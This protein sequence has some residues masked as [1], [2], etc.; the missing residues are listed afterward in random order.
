ESNFGRQVLPEGS[1]RCGPF[2]Y[3]A[4]EQVRAGFSR[5][6]ALAPR[7]PRI[8]H[9]HLPQQ[10]APL[11]PAQPPAQAPALGPAG[12]GEAD[13][14]APTRA[15]QGQSGADA[16]DVL[17][18]RSGIPRLAL[19]AR[20]AVDDPAT[21]PDRVAP[22]AGAVGARAHGHG[23]PVLHRGDPGGGQG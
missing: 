17:E 11:E 8:V 16:F 15:S 9:H 6:V 2:A 13:P 3:G 22:T 1:Q 5:A 23:G 12:W 7:P 19:V 10:P 4:S 21:F 18:Y 20:V 14:C